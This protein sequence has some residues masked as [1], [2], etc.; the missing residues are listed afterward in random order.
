MFGALEVKLGEEELLV[1]LDLELGLIVV[2][3]LDVGGL[4][5]DEA[6]HAQQQYK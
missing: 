4:I 3:A 6:I 2:L 1:S 5:L